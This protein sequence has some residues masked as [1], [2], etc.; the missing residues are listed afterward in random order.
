ME[1]SIPV[2][3]ENIVKLNELNRVD[4]SN[5]DIL[6][7]NIAFALMLGMDGTDAFVTEGWIDVKEADEVNT[8]IQNASD[9]AIYDIVRDKAVLNSAN[10]KKYRKSDAERLSE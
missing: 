4:M 2:T 7:T 1:N 5:P 3:S 8:A 9:E 10:L 6:T